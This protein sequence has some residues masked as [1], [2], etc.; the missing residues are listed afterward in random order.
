MIYDVDF[1][2]PE[3]MNEEFEAVV[4]VIGGGQENGEALEKLARKVDGEIE[5]AQRAEEENKQAITAEVQRAQRAEM[6]LGK[7][8]D[9]IPN[10]DLSRYATKDDVNK[11]QDAIADLE[12]I[13]SGAEKGATAVQSDVLTTA[14][15]VEKTRAESA[16][17]ALGDR[18]NAIKI[19]EVDLSGYVKDTDLASVAK[20]GSYDDLKNKPTI[21]NAVTESTVSGWGFTKNTGTYIKP[22]N[23]IPASDLSQEV[24]DALSNAGD[25]PVAEQTEATATIAPNVLNV[26]GEVSSLD[27]TLGEAK[28]GVINE[29]MFQFTSGTTPTTLVL[30]VDIKWV[31]APNIQA[32]KTYQVSI[33][34]N[35][36]VIGEFSHE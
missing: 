21:P 25:I 33:I 2:V 30:P 18:I 35:L 26:W 19:P 15:N 8:I 1:T 32:N 6:A 29:Y 9:N 5:R 28:E 10:P 20:S 31:S 12:T 24:Q 36:G 11:K 34:N 16:E 7:R 14:I 13:R 4:P 27:I 23:G 3:M 17:K 22:V